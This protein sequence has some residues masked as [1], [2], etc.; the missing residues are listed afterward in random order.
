MTLPGDEPLTNLFLPESAGPAQNVSYRQGVIL[1][2]NQN[3]LQNTVL[4]GDTVLTDLPLLG[5]GESTLLKPGSVVGIIVIGDNTRAKSY[6]IIGRLVT[7]NTAEATNAVTLLNSQIYSDFIGDPLETI[8]STV[9][10]DLPRIGPKV[11]VPVGPTGRVLMIVSAQIQFN[12]LAGASTFNQGRIAVDITGANTI[13]ASDT[14]PMLNMFSI[15]TVVSAG[16]IAHLFVVS[17]TQ[18]AN[19]TGLNPG[20]TTFKMMYKNNAAATNTSDVT[21]RTLTVIKL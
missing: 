21:R 20:D 14:G 16:T 8:T 3:T 13:P 5:V 18:Q 7:P 17:S 12:S 6:A 10:Q 4:V 9:Y 2:F 11:T 19:L 15:N 1:T